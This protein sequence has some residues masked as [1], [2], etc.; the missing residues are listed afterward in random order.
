M[1][2]TIAEPVW[3]FRIDPSFDEILRT[4]DELHAMVEAGPQWM[5]FDLETGAGHIK[6]AGVSWSRLDALCIPFL[7]Q[8]NNTY[9][10]A[11][12]EEGEAEIIWRLYKLLT[13]PNCW[14]RG[15]NLLYDAQY[16]YRHWHFAPNVKQDTMISQHTVFAGMKKSLDYQASMYCQSYCQWKPERDG[17]W[18]D[19]G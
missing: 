16:T 4:L 1:S 10:D 19:G 5:D 13:H 9:V 11:W 2:P 7:R 17:G 14:V 3:Q 6:C 15:Q 8:V 18:K 12:G